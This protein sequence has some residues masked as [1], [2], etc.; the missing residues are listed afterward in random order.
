MHTCAK[1][2][3]I[4]SHLYF[5]ISVFVSQSKKLYQ[6]LVKMHI[7]KAIEQKRAQWLRRK[8]LVFLSQLT[9]RCRV[10]NKGIKHKPRSQAETDNKA[11]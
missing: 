6:L 10:I 7:E 8:H 11:V 2:I 1:N 4:T 3:Q 5:T 9:I